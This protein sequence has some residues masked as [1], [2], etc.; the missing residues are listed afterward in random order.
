MEW[1]QMENFQTILVD[2]GY[3]KHTNT[4][5]RG[6]NFPSLYC[7]GISRY[8]PWFENDMTLMVITCQNNLK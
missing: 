6:E 2:I 4:H 8:I 7:C 3:R 1:L 5:T